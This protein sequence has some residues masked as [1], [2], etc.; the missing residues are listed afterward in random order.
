MTI[1]KG[2]TWGAPFRLPD[3]APV[4]D[5]D[6]TIFHW[7]NPEVSAVSAIDG[8]CATLEGPAIGLVGGS[9]WKML[10]GA[11]CVGRVRTAGAL[12]Y[13]CD[14]IEVSTDRGRFRCLSALSAHTLLWSRVLLAMNVQDLGRFRF[15]HRAHPGD[16]LVDVYEAQLPLQQRVLVARRAR[17]GA[18]LP[19]PGIHEQR[20][21]EFAVDFV[22]PLSFRLDGVRCGRSSV[23]AVKVLPDAITVVI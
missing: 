1:G 6:A 14:L 23:F 22:R 3:S 17:L 12:G 11:S 10:G 16:G 8:L 2:T 9:L 7:L 13:P 5:S 20:V 19:H 15:G 4:F 18:H 21:T